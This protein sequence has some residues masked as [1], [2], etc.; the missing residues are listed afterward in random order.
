MSSHS[1]SFTSSSY[2]FS[3]SSTNNNGQTTGTTRMTQSHT[4]PDGTTVPKAANSWAFPSGSSNNQRRLQDIEVEDV[5]DESD[6]D[7]K[8]REAMEDEY[9]KREGGA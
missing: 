1:S 2:S 4:N 6:A 3:S 7:K 9:A 5:T 8:Y